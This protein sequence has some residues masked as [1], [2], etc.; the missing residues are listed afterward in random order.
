MSDEFVYANESD[1]PNGH[2]EVF[3]IHHWS[4]SILWC[5]TCGQVEALDDEHVPT[6]PITIAYLIRRTAEH[7]AELLKEKTMDD[8]RPDVDQLLGDG[9]LVHPLRTDR[10]KQR[11]LYVRTME[12][13]WHGALW[14]T[15]D[16]VT[17]R[18]LPAYVG[19]RP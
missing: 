2:H 6:V 8:R 18:D 3:A 11:R 1:R 10:L 7:A 15:D 13:G 5:D 9:V 4:G 12:Q 19:P 16:E 14:L 17:D